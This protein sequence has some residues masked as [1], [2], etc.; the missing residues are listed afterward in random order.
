MTIVVAGY[1]P[2][3]IW[4]AQVLPNLAAN[5]QILSSKMDDDP[6]PLNDAGNSFG[7]LEDAACV[8]S[9]QFIDVGRMQ[10]PT[11]PHDPPQ[12]KTPKWE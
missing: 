6:L 8:I 1:L 3:E 5:F 12:K 10:L 2:A 7:L 4:K 9:R 11:R